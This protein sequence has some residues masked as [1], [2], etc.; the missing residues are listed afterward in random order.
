[1]PW[2]V[3]AAEEANLKADLE[4][5]DHAME[6]ARAEKNLEAKKTMYTKESKW[7]ELWNDY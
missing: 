5:K 1:M 4:R 7:G 2:C 3:S 6:I